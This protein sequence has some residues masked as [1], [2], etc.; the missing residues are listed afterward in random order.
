MIMKKQIF[1]LIALSILFASCSTQEIGSDDDINNNQGISS[2]ELFKYVNYNLD[3]SANPPIPLDSTVYTILNNRYHE[4]TRYLPSGDTRASMFIY[5]NNKIDRVEYY[6]NGVLAVDETQ[7]FTYGSNG[8]VSERLTYNSS[9]NTYTKRTYS[10]V[11]DTTYVYVFNSN[12][13]INFTPATISSK[14]VTDAQDKV[15]YVERVDSTGNEPSTYINYIYDGMGNLVSESKDRD[16]DNNGTLINDVTYNMTYTTIDNPIA[17]IRDNTYSR[18]FNNINYY[19]RSGSVNLTIGPT[20][21]SPK[22]IETYEYTLFSSFPTRVT[23][24]VNTDGNIETITYLTVDSGGVP[25]TSFTQKFS[26]Q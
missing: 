23:N 18:Y 3:V 15:T 9:L 24:Q 2:S 7:I 20:F 10:K 26:Y 8:L 17:A 25:F 16:Y 14:V 1:Y 13:G 5:S 4:I 6:N 19:T 12:D 11:A 21:I 22:Q